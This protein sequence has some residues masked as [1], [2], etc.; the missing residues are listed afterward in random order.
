[1]TTKIPAALKK[2]LDA[3]NMIE[4]VFTLEAVR[5]LSEKIVAT[6][7]LPK[8]E[9]PLILC[10]FFDINDYKIAVRIYHPNPQQK[11]PVMLYFHGGGHICGSLDS[12]DSFCRRIA[13]ASECIVISVGYRLAPEFPYPAGLLDCIEAFKQRDRLLQDLQADT[14]RVFLAGDSAGG[15]LA[16]SVCYQLKENNDTFI[17]SLVL[18]YPSVDYSTQYDSYKSKGE[19]YLLT[20]EKIKWYFDQYFLNGGDRFKA[21]PIHFKQLKLLPPIYIA[22]AEYDP[23]FDEGISFAQKVQKLGVKVVVDEFKGMIHAFIQLEL[24]VPDQV[25]QLATAIRN[26]IKHCEI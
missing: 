15:N 9:L 17:K 5:E 21:S 16:L 19:K 24:L 13:L 14:T 25:T 2:F 4:P 3:V 11:L 1:M 26:F 18:I 12:H 22:L 6:Y 20:Q 10:R 23:L 8:L 7:S